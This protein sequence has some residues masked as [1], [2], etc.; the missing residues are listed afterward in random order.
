MLGAAVGKDLDRMCSESSPASRHASIL[1]TNADGV[2]SPIPGHSRKKS[3]APFYGRPAKCRKEAI[4]DG[5]VASASSWGVPDDVYHPVHKLALK[6]C[7]YIAVPGLVLGN[8]RNMQV[9]FCLNSNKPVFNP[10]R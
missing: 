2:P 4:F 7:H 9:K 8:G 1:L 10:V 3:L 6:C 5:L